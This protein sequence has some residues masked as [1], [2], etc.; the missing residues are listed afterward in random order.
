[1]LCAIKKPAKRPAFSSNSRITWKQK[2]KLLLELEQLRKLLEL[3]R[4]LRQRQLELLELL[5]Q[6]RMLELLQVL[7]LLRML[8][9]LLELRRLFCRKLPKRL[10]TGKRARGIF[11]CL[12]FLQ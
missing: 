1:M 12:Y 3:R 10:P 9:E 11:S 2:R 8:L 5:L 7:E 6:E 4:K